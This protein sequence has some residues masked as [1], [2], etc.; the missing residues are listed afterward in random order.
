MSDPAAGLD[1]SRISAE[2]F[3]GLVKN[4]KDGQIEQTIRSVGVDRVL[5]RIFQGFE[6]RFRADKATGVDADVV[7]NV[8]DEGRDHPYTVSVHDGSCTAKA[9][10]TEN[11]RTTLNVGLVPFARLVTGDADGMRLFMTGKLK[12]SGDVMFAA[13]L[14]GYFEPPTAPN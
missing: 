5:D 8:T 10:A 14:M 13:G 1:P 2:E 6:E 12:V 7:F 4:A 9:S 11:A 3:A